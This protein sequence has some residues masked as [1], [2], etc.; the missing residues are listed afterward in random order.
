[1]LLKDIK[2]PDDGLRVDYILLQRRLVTDVEL[3]DLEDLQQGVVVFRMHQGVEHVDVVL[4][5]QA[6]FLS[7]LK[8]L[9]VGIAYI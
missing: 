5:V 8:G 6:I 3:D 2:K 1:L 9:K 7:F 4:L